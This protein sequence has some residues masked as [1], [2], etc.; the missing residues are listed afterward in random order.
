M[1]G[2]VLPENREHWPASALHEWQERC[3]IMG[4]ATAEDETWAEAVVRAYW[5]VLRGGLDPE[6]ARVERLGEE[7]WRVGSEG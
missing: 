1:R 6:R 5:A 3:A 4:A 2:R 7:P